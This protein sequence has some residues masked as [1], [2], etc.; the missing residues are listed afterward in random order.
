MK[1]SKKPNYKGFGLTIL[2]WSKLG[3]AYSLSDLR[4][5]ARKYNCPIPKINFDKKDKSE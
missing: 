4:E 1:K 5:L 3:V 2:E